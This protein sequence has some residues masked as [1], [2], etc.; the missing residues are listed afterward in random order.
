M[1]A[2][3]LKNGIACFLVAVL[4]LICVAL[5]V[6]AG[7]KP[8]QVVIGYQPFPT[9]EII[10]K[11]QGL[12]EKTFGVPVKWVTVSSGMQAHQALASGDLDIALLGSSP[13]AAAVAKGIPI[14]VIWIHDIIG[15]NEALVVRKGEGIT[16]PAGL[17]GRTAAA[18]FGST[19]HYHLMVS[20]MLGNVDER[21]VTV[22]NLEPNDILTA[23]NKCEIDAA[24]I[25][26]PVLN[27]L[28]GAG[29]KS[30]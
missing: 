18:P 14:S 2:S 29:G 26:A 17:K 27:Q 7:E 21:D 1:T 8:D 10:V 19:T 23:W 24:F 30:S 4:A 22:I 25:W 5:P 11:D 12:N 6:S 9:A 16:S 3:G 15:D 28:V 20:L 13:S